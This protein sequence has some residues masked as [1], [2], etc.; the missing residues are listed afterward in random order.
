MGCIEKLVPL[1]QGD[2]S[3]QGWVNS[4]LGLK[5]LTALENFADVFLEV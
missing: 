3:R 4:P 2:G 1:P 5:L